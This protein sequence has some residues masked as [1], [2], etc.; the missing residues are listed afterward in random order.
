MLLMT[1]SS[2]SLRADSL[3]ARWLIFKAIKIKDVQ[4]GFTGKLQYEMKPPNE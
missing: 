4:G 2:N 3:G 1:L